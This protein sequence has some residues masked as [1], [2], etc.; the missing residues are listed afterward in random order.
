MRN[1]DINVWQEKVHRIETN[2]DNFLNIYDE[3]ASKYESL[4]IIIEDQ[5]TSVEEKALIIQ[6]LEKDSLKAKNEIS[7]LKNA[8]TIKDSHDRLDSFRHLD[9][10]TQSTNSLA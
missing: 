7:R 1:T 9:N 8:V 10:R 3:M 5:K 4:Q 6:K 2:Y